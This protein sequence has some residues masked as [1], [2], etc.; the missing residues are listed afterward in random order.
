MIDFG[1][2]GGAPPAERLEYVN[3]S[4]HVDLYVVLLST[5]KVVGRAIAYRLPFFHDKYKL[6]RHLI[7]VFIS[8]R[9]RVMSRILK[10]NR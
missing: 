2:Q 4:K 9:K 7:K 10:S 3:Q 8:N 1:V 6:E 5:T